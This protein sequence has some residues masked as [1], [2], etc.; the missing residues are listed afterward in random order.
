MFHNGQWKNTDPIWFWF[1]ER[2]NSRV[3]ILEVFS[4]CHP[5]NA[6]YVMSGG[7]LENYIFSPSFVSLVSSKF[8]H[9]LALPGDICVLSEAQYG[10]RY[11]KGILQG[12]L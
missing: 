6:Q 4:R 2:T 1:R 5:P 12:P 9:L 3:R 7:V 11:D 10:Q 8:S